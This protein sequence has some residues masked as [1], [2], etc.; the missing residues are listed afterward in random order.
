[1]ETE[2][3]ITG[4]GNIIPPKIDAVVNDFIIGYNTIIE[5]L[6]MR[7]GSDNVGVLSK[8]TCMLCGY[9]GVLQDSM[10]CASRYV[11]GKFEIHFDES[12]MD[13]F[14]IYESDTYIDPPTS[15][16]REGTYYLL[17]YRRNL[18][19]DDYELAVTKYGYPLE[20]LRSET[21]NQLSPTGTIGDGVTTPTAPVSDNSLR[22]A[23]T[24]YVQKQIAHD[25]NEGST[26]VNIY[27]SNGSSTVIA[28]MTLRRRAKY[29][30]GK[31]TQTS[32]YELQA[33]PYFTLP[34]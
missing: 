31:I 14:S 5:G 28:T 19:Y 3:I 24:E 25:I 33:S 9:R 10:L 22:V 26:T 20:S 34:I 12:F 1:M 16:T 17:L 8:G 27:G 2:G 4:V 18:T 6:S 23:N 21:S 7:V 32:S 11:Y 15:I 29:V 13:K 30:I